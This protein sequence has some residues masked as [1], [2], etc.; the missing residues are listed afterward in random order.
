MAQPIPRNMTTTIR[1]SEFETLR[2]ELNLSAGVTMRYEDVFGDDPGRRPITMEAQQLLQERDGESVV[3]GWIVNMQGFGEGTV[4][5]ITNDRELIE[6]LRDRNIELTL[7]K[8]I[9]HEEPRTRGA[10]QRR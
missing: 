3:V 10:V 9:Q 7:Q 1:A 5:L 2:Q 4:Y 8:P 6:Q